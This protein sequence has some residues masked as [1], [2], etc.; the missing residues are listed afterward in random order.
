MI[1]KIPKGEYCGGCQL[2][3]N[4]QF[5]LLYCTAYDRSLDYTF[6]EVLKCEQCLDKEIIKVEYTHDN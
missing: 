5:P 6:T 2:L 4:A 1:I 3:T